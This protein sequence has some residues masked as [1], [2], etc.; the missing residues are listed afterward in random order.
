MIWFGCVFK[1]NAAGHDYFLGSRALGWFP[2]G[3]S[4]MATQLSAVSLCPRRL[5]SACAMAVECN[6]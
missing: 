2:L 6:G 1:R 4:T 5:S 3:M